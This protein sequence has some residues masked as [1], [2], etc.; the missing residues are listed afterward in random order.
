MHTIQVGKFKSE[1]SSILDKVQKKGE[2]FII[3]YGRKHEKVAILIPY[4]KKYE[5]GEK[6]K[7]GL[8]KGK[9][10]IPEDF[11]DENGQIDE[12]FYGEIQ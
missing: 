4:N 8:L 3:E 5:E 10:E 2:K 9:I 11:T 1:F 7:F 6:R 12:M